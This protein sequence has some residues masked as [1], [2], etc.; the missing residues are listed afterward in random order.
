MLPDRPNIFLQVERQKRYD[1]EVDLEWIVDGLREQQLSYP[2]TII[3]CSSVMT[4]ADMFIHIVATLGKDAY[5]GK[6][7]FE[8]RLVS[9]H[10]GESGEA[11]QE[12]NLKTFP[13]EDSVI[14]VLVVAGAFGMGVEISDI[15]QVVHWGKCASALCYWQEVSRAGRD[16]QPSKAIWYPKIISPKD[17][18]FR[19]LRQNQELCVRRTILKHFVLPGITQGLAALEAPENAQVAANMCCNHCNS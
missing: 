15:R 5:V 18:L 12:Y 3:Y 2:K 6:A 16:G 10:H 11:L 14:R 9:M 19:A 4:T 1:Y 7:A 13:K 8:T 17:Q